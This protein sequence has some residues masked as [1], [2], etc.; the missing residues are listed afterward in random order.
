MLYEVI[1]K[2]TD[3]GNTTSPVVTQIK[4]CKTTKST[5][6]KTKTFN[7]MRI[8]LLFMVISI[9][10]NSKAQVATLPSGSGTKCDPYQI[11][12]LENLYWMYQNSSSWASIV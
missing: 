12:S 3:G 7:L 11:A 8:A 1:T 4:K 9:S 2:V 5:D 6:M 10:A